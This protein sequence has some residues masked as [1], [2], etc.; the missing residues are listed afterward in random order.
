MVT[1]ATPAHGELWHYLPTIAG[2]QKP[3]SL[4]GDRVLIVSRTAANAILPTVL[5]IPVELAPKMPGL[6]VPFDDADPLPGLSAVVY[7]ITPVY[8]PWLQDRIGVV[9]E[10][11]LRQVVGALVG[12][13]APDTVFSPDR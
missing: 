7:R 9:T 12:L 13:V 1:A 5:A 11:T 3:S 4:G 2:R 10:S 6:A 8:R